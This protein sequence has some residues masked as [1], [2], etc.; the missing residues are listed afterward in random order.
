MHTHKRGVIVAA[1]GL[2]V[3]LAGCGVTGEGESS[4]PTSETSGPAWAE[5]TLLH[6]T[7]TEDAVSEP[8]KEEVAKAVRAVHRWRQA[9][10]AAD[11]GPAATQSHYEPLIDAVARFS[12]ADPA[13]PTG[14][15]R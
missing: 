8:L 4:P 3:A 9:L 14:L 13:A 15:A 7:L 11:N 10:Y 6:S 12:P 5:V 1:L 2:L